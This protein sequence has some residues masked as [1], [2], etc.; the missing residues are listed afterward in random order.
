MTLGYPKEILSDNG[1]CFR[2]E[3]ST[4]FHEKLGVTE[5]KSSSYNHQ[6]VG[7]VKQMVQTIKQIVT[8]NA[9]NAWLAI[10]MFKATDIPG[11][12]K[13]LGELLNARKYRTNLPMIYIHQK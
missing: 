9:E 8:R 6:S 11:I 12:N 7:T 5:E 4:N 2:S 13:S 1:P 3:E 10:V